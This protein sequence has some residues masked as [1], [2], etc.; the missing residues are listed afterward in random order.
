[1]GEQTDRYGR[2]LNPYNDGGDF[3]TVANAMTDEARMQME[4]MPD[5]ANWYDDDVREALATTAEV[6]PEIEQSA[7]N[8]QLYLLLAVTHHLGGHKL[9]INWRYAGSLAMHYFRT[10][11]IGE[12]GQ[13]FS[14]KRGTSEERTVNP[15]TGFQGIRP[16]G[17]VYRT[18]HQH[19]RPYDQQTWCRRHSGL[20]AQR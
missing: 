15:T 4:K 1:M 14:E 18:W 16:Q 13:V 19:Q 3:E 6:I 8:K 5:A 11:N 7:D 20:G 12:R 10:G 9:R 17:A 2:E